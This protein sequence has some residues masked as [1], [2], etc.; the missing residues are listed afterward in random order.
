[1]SSSAWIGIAT[2]FISAVVFF[3]IDRALSKKTK[4]GSTRSL[5][6]FVI[7]MALAVAASLVIKLVRE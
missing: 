1:M 2:G 4:S 7:T 3:W 5:T 6:A